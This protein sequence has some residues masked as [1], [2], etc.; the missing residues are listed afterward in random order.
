MAPN[1][2]GFPGA[3]S[4]SGRGAVVSLQS[5]RRGLWGGNRHIEMCPRQSSAEG[6][7]GRARGCHWSAVLPLPGPR[8]HRNDFPETSRTSWARDEDGGLRE[9]VLGTDRADECEQVIQTRTRDRCLHLG[10]R[11]LLLGECT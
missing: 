8:K 3:A 9:N 5:P 10:T 1:E 11:E 4:V 6:R 2:Q 7:A